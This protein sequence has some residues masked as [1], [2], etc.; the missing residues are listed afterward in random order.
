MTKT[1]W[2]RS[3]LPSIVCILLL[4]IL[5]LTL[6][7]QHVNALSIGYKINELTNKKSD[8]EHQHRVLLLEKASLVDYEKIEKK[9][10]LTHGFR[11]PNPGEQLIYMVE[12]SRLILCV[13]EQGRG[14]NP[15]H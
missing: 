9:A 15:S 1:G 3:L 11:E 7:W 10:R 4:V 14:S 2:I 6:A 5:G 8:L 13:P 12:S